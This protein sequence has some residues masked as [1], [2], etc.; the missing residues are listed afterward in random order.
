MTKP[1]TCHFC[2]GPYKAC[3]EDRDRCPE[4]D[5]RFVGPAPVPFAF[6]EGN[7]IIRLRG[8]GCFCL[9]DCENADQVV[10]LLLVAAEVNP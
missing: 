2:G 6:H 10:S 4:Y 1:T 3:W 7:G 9:S 5:D 8:G